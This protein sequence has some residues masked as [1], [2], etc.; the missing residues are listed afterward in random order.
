MKARSVREPAP[1]GFGAMA[2]W[3]AIRIITPSERTGGAR[4]HGRACKDGPNGAVL[5]IIKSSHI[6]GPERS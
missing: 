5:L 6:R 2:A 1:T 4:L 3:A